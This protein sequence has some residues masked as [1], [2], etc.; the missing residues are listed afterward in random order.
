M[1][2]KITE[3]SDLIVEYGQLSFFL[4]LLRSV[5]IWPW[6]QVC[7]VAHVAPPPPLPRPGKKNGFVK[8]PVQWQRLIQRE[9]GGSFS[10]RISG[11]F[12]KNDR[13]DSSHQ[14]N[15]WPCPSPPHPPPPR[16]K[17][18]IVFVKTPVQWQRGIQWVSGLFFM[19]NFRKI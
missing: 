11:K 15:T 8:T 14:S 13:N 19:E 3:I 4:S 12:K 5:I 17:K 7:G 10:G 18:K 2:L 1:S 9:V 16:K 6:W